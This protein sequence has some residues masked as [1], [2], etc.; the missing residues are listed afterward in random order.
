MRFWLFITGVFGCTAAMHMVF[1][2]VIITTSAIS[3]TGLAWLAIS[4]INGWDKR[5]HDRW[6]S[7]KIAATDGFWSIFLGFLGASFNGMYGGIAGMIAG[8]VVS[9]WLRTRKRYSLSNSPP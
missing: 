1:G 5:R 8:V 2:S 4:F 6:T 7:F 9:V 3:G